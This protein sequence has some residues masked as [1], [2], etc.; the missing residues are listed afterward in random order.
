MNHGTSVRPSF[1]NILRAATMIGTLI[2]VAPAQAAPTAP[3]PFGFRRFTVASQSSQ[4]GFDGSSSLHDF[5]GKTKKVDGE[6]HFDERVLEQT[7]GGL[8]GIDAASLD[9]DEKDRDAEMRKRLA[10][11][12]FPKITFGL[13]HI[14]GSLVNLSGTVKARGKFTIHG[15]PRER[16]FD[17]TFEAT[18]GG[19]RV[20]GSCKFKMTDHGIEPPVAFVVTTSDEVKVWF[21]VLFVPVASDTVV[22]KAWDADVTETLT[23]TLGDPTTS[24]RRDQILAF[25]DRLVWYRPETG[26]AARLQGETL[27]RLDLRA[28]ATSGPPDAC[29]SQFGE[30]RGRLEGMKAKIAALPEEKRAALLGKVQDTIKRLEAA[31]ALAPEAGD[32][33]VTTTEAASTLKLGTTT[34][35]SFE[36]AAGDARLGTML[37]ALDGQPRA[38]RAALPR[39]VGVPRTL[40]LR[41]VAP[42]GTRTVRWTIQPVADVAVPKWMDDLS[43]WTHAA[44]QGVSW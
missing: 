31:I 33:V 2:A 10:T 43:S 34:W 17:V 18:D 40:S 1:A 12:R 44:E 35:L 42:A 3:A 21:D 27:T 8:V 14:T 9:T 30:A 6:I 29:D 41:T 20:K 24:Q 36:A 37:G 5:S 28:A 25:G 38:V 23:P 22:A 4:A 32:A 26:T 7:A 16:T 15:V 13:D 39:L 11:D 19:F